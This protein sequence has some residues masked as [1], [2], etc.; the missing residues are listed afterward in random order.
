MPWDSVGCRGKKGR[1]KYTYN[2]IF[3]CLRQVARQLCLRVRHGGDCEEDLEVRATG[4]LVLALELGQHTAV[5]VVLSV[6]P[7]VEG[8]LAAVERLDELPARRARGH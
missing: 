6:H 8:E 1:S 2:G 5:G 4:V 7:F 3:E